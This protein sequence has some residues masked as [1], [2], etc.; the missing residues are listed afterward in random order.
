MRNWMAAPRLTTRCRDALV[1][2]VLVAAGFAAGAQERLPPFANGELNEQQA[3]AAT[4]FAAAR[5]ELTGPWIALLRSP[6]LMTRT[7]ELGDYL[8][9]ES[10]VPGYLREFAVL[11]TAREWGQAYEWNDHYPLAIEQ[12]FSAEMAKAVAEGRRPEGMVDEEEILYDFCMELQRNHSVSDA[13]YERAVSRFSEQG[14]V[15]IVSLMGYYT[16]MSMIS[17]ASRVA[18]P[19]GVAAA[20][21]LAPFPR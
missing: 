15:E 18:A 21:T 17:N 1:A 20:P 14:V 19:V 13:T 10:V 16:M 3:Q 6:V 4:D 9:F 5:G 12:G 7:R 11:L 8:D 2:T